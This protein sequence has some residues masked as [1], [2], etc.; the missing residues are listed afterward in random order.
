MM[1]TMIVV[2]STS[3][4]VGQTTLE[5]SARTCWINWIGLVRAIWMPLG[6]IKGQ[7]RAVAGNFKRCNRQYGKGMENVWVLYIRTPI[8]LSAAA[9]AITTFATPL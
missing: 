8:W 9:A 1:K 2:N 3:R 4:R 6:L 7:I 5:T